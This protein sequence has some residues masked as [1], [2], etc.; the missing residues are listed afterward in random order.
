MKYLLLALAFAL[1]SCQSPG[2]E[3]DDSTPRETEERRARSV[4]SV[5]ALGLPTNEN[6]ALLPAA[7][8][9]DVRPAV[10]VADRAIAVML[11]AIK[12]ERGH[13]Q[14][15]DESLARFGDRAAFTPEEAAFIE[16][17][18]PEMQT[19]VDFSWRFECLH[20]LLWSLGVI[21]ELHAPGDAADIGTDVTIVLDGGA[22]FGEGASMLPAGKLLDAAD[23][24]AH[25]LW[26]GRALRTSG[27]ELPEALNYSVAYE[28]LRALRWLVD[29]RGQSWDD[30]TLETAE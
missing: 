4:A 5:A 17:D 1:V 22:S 23:Y 30:V 21:P 19:R 26:A 27:A 7:D 16:D 28:R 3:T 2:S 8:A 13:D 25:L 14:S 20:V 10:A 18:A 15:F 6:L 29:Y 24:Y 12:G 9:L 11:T